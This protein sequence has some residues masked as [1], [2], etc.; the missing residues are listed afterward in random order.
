MA[1]AV[2]LIQF[3]IIIMAGMAVI[4]TGTH[5]FIR[6]FT[7]TRLK[8]TPKDLLTGVLPL[9][10]VLLPG[11]AGEDQ[12]RL[13]EQPHPAL[14]VSGEPA[15]TLHPVPAPGLHLTAEAE[16]SAQ[17]WTENVRLFAPARMLM[18]EE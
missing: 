14:L 3:H 4:T 5:I 12:D 18:S 6:R 1:I 11:A 8:N 7:T 15:E 17:T 9:D 10:P 13:M 2:I 16:L